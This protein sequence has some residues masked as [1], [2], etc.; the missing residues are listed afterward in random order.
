V[1]VGLLVESLLGKVGI[2]MPGTDFRDVWMVY[3][4]FY[5]LTC[6]GMRRGKT[7]LLVGLKRSNFF[8]FRLV[9]LKTKYRAVLIYVF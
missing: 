3:D 5:G 4:A 1:I 7:S 2:A 6:R 9:F 8:K